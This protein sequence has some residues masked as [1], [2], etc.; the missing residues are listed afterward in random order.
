MKT[1]K[2]AVF[3]IQLQLFIHYHP[4]CGCGMAMFSQASVILF[5][6]GEGVWQTPHEQTP[7]QTPL[8]GRPPW[9]DTPSR[10]TPWADTPWA[11]T[12]WSDTPC[13]DTPCPVHTGMHTLPAHCMLGY[14]PPAQCMLA[15][16]ASD[17]IHPTGMHSC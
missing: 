8:P 9:A 13:P 3:A 6:G 17:D 10:Y 1:K 5:T 14:T 11:D 7:R 12:P 4:Q 2:Y 16:T 15:A